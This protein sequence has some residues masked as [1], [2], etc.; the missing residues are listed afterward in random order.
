MNGVVR[1]NSQIHHRSEIR[2]PRIHSQLAGSD[3]VGPRPT[4]ACRSSSRSDI[5]AILQRWGGGALDVSH[6]V[7]LR[8]GPI[9][10]RTS[11]LHNGIYGR[12]HEKLPHKCDS[13][14]VREMFGRLQGLGQCQGSPQKKILPHSG[15]YL[16]TTRPRCGSCCRL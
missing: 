2:R 3:I 5:E 13:G 1:P 11:G 4:F 12:I 14:S 16:R 7:K 6:G 8:D 10:S 9:A 15:R